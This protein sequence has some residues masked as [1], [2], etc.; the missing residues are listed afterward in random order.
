MGR[1]KPQPLGRKLAGALKKAGEFDGR[2]TLESNETF[3]TK[4]SSL[5]HEVRNERCSISYPGHLPNLA[6]RQNIHTEKRTR[7]VQD[8]RKMGIWED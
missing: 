2:G 7:W 3:R 4:T 1:K 6:Q 8:L 5:S